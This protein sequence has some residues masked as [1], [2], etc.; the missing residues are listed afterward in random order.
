MDHARSNGA[1][2]DGGRRLAGRGGEAGPA[3]GSGGDGSAA[4]AAGSADGSAAGSADE[5]GSGGDGSA[6]GSDAGSAAGSADGSAAV[7]A[8]NDAGSAVGSDAGSAVG[9]DA[10]SAAVAVGS[11]AGSAAGSDAGSAAMAAGSGTAVGGDDAPTTDRL[12]VRSTP[13]GAMVVIDGA[14]Q[15]EA[16]VEVE[17][18]TDSHNLAVFLPGHALHLAQVPGTGTVDVVLTPVTPTGAPAGIKV[19]CK[20]AGRYY[21]YVDG[22]PTGMLCPTERIEV[23]KGEHV[24]EIYDLVSETRRQFPVTV[25]DTRN[26]LRVRVD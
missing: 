15:G 23:T 14:E 26:S 13:T 12:R 21:V 19:R 24:V 5:V 7:A 3:T 20:Q 6:A 17:G 18:S 9:S 11:A 16:P 25:K 22:A 4:M 2:T 8:G 10:G 1:G